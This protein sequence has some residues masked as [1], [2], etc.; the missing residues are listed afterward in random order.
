MPTSS[1]PAPTTA[2]PAT[3]PAAP[4]PAVPQT[5]PQLFA[6]ALPAYTGPGVPSYISSRASSISTQIRSMNEDQLNDFLNRDSIYAFFH[7]KDPKVG[8]YF[9]Q[10]AI[11]DWYSLCGNKGHV[12]I[13][14]GKEKFH[15]MAQRFVDAPFD[16]T[17]DTVMEYGG[18][19]LSFASSHFM[20][21]SGFALAGISVAQ[22]DKHPVWGAIGCIAG[23]LMLGT[24]FGNKHNSFI[25]TSTSRSTTPSVPAPGVPYAGPSAPAVAPAG[26]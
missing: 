10:L 3:P 1:T 4:T 14:V 22:M 6:D 21:A 25:G 8:N 26:P 17:V 20:G 9:D 5:N 18:K 23:L 15:D 7:N 2:A 12:D 13:S 19:T 24:E 11:N 16:T